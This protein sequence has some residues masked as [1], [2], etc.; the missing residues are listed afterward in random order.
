M[1]TRPDPTQ[2]TST[3]PR[4]HST[5]PWRPYAVSHPSLL[6]YWPYV[7]GCRMTAMGEHGRLP[8]PASMIGSLALLD[9]IESAVAYS[10]GVAFPDGFPIDPTTQAIREVA[11][12]TFSHMLGHVDTDDDDDRDTL[13]TDIVIIVASYLNGVVG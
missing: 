6:P 13:L 7:A 12:V 2:A 11:M 8:T 5:S 10:L 4:L 9:A 1:T 3:Q